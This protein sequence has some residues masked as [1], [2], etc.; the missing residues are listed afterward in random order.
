[1]KQLWILNHYTVAP[2]ESGGTR[3]FGLARHLVE[4]GW[5]TSLLAASVEHDTGKQRLEDGRKRRLD[6]LDRVR[7]LWLRT[8]GY[9]GNGGGRMLN[10]L[11]YSLRVLLPS[12]TRV[13]PRPD[14]IIG[15]SVHPFAAL[16]G[17]ILA[18]RFR[19]PFIFEVRDLWPQTLIDLGRLQ[20]GSLTTKFLQ[21]LEHWLYRRADKIIVLLPR[22]GEYI[23]PLGIEAE[24]IVWIPNGVELDETK[25]PEDAPE[26]SQ[27]TLMYFGAH[28]KANGLD[29]VIKAM[30][31]LQERADC[32]HIRLTMVGGGPQK[33][34]LINL[35]ETLGAKNITFLDSVPKEEIPTVATA[36]DAFVI[37]VLDRPDLYRFGIS[38]NK[39]FDYLAAS[40]PIVISSE[41]VNNPVDEA[42]AG[43][44]V[45]PENPEAL[46]KAIAE[47]AALPAS[48]RAS[49]G[50][51]GRQYVESNH[52][53]RNLASKLARTLEEVLARKAS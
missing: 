12:V 8:P 31:I 49:M 3:H 13:L 16:S 9:R 4:H 44:T 10:M 41:A 48:E 32:T 38:M 46:A 14:V 45:P 18:R 11:A 39:I 47:M 37:C 1:M 50:H 35:A 22:A 5:E 36:A 42:G 26:H 17:A 7:F 29:N 15:S 52:T 51:A 40:R 19:V 23:E 28:G 30:V 21:K 53:Y 33:S 6:I 25:T 34:T 2:T 20:P 27:F 43:V 24:K